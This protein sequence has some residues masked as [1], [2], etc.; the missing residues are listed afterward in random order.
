MIK[1][2]C[3][4]LYD[5]VY[6][7]WLL[8][9]KGK[10]FFFS[11]HTLSLIYTQTISRS[12]SYTHQLALHPPIHRWINNEPMLAMC[13][14]MYLQLNK[15][16]AGSLQLTHYSPLDKQGADVC[17]CFNRL[18]KIHELPD[19]HAENDLQ[20]NIMELSYCDAHRLHTHTQTSVCVCV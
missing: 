10:S 14:C 1:S 8:Y 4:T 20:E 11:S 18:E 5:K 15:P 12:P 19:S 3:L 17:V 9:H 6:P 2:T 16:G 7:H 13:V